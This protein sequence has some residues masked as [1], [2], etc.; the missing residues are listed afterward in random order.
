MCNTQ[1]I[2]LYISQHLSQFLNLLILPVYD[3]RPKVPLPLLFVGSTFG[4]ATNWNK[5]SFFLFRRTS[6]NLL[7]NLRSKWLYNTT[8]VAEVTISDGTQITILYAWSRKQIGHCQ[9]SEL[10]KNHI[11]LGTDILS[12]DETVVECIKSS[13]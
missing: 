8:S 6:S 12:G 1:R 2:F 5:H 9:W 4:L 7:N 11:F 13:P 3:R 10:P